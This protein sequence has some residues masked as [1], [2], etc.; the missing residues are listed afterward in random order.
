LKSN[1]IWLEFGVRQ[2]SLTHSLL[3]HMIVN[4]EMPMHSLFLKNLSLLVWLELVTGMN[5]KRMLF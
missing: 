4:L 2:Q 3:T 1:L 5:M